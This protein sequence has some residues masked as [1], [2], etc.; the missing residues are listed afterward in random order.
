MLNSTADDLPLMRSAVLVSQFLQVSKKRTCK[1]YKKSLP[2][3]LVLD[4]PKLSFLEFCLCWDITQNARH[5]LRPV[6]H[7]ISATSFWNLWVNR[8]IA[9]LPGS[10]KMALECWLLLKKVIFQR[11]ATGLSSLYYFSIQML[12]PPPCLDT[13]H[14]N[15]HI[16]TLISWH[17][18]YKLEFCWWDLILDSSLDL[19]LGFLYREL[20]HSVFYFSIRFA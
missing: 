20:K 15:T 6:Q 12:F 4:E 13:K 19:I 5:R 16:H 10:L 9:S 1:L 7:Q 18:Q 3:T 8:S 2:D 17:F 11:R 14:T